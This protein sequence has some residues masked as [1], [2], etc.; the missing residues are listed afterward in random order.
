MAQNVWLSANKP[1]M[2]RV[3]RT[4]IEYEYRPEFDKFPLRQIQALL[5]GAEAEILKLQNEL[6]MKK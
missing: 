4:L 1:A 3:K 5:Q 6:V 2:E